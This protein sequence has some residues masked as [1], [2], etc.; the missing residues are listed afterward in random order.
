MPISESKIRLIILAVSKSF[1]V[2]KPQDESARLF[3]WQ[4]L[5]ARFLSRATITVAVRATKANLDSFLEPLG[6]VKG[7]LFVHCSYRKVDYAQSGSIYQF[8]ANLIIAVQSSTSFFH[9]ADTVFVQRVYQSLSVLILIRIPS[10][11]NVKLGTK[12]C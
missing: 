10:L 12:V 4:T 9:L 2:S 7:S 8:C 5:R 3:P 1:A 11:S 6:T